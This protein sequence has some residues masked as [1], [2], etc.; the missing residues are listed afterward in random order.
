MSY[1]YLMS[2]RRHIQ[3][4]VTV[5]KCYERQSHT[6]G[7]P[8]ILNGRYQAVLVSILDSLLYAYLVRAKTLHRTRTFL[9]VQHVLYVNS[10]V[11]K[12][13]A[14]SE[15]CLCYRI[16]ISTYF[17]E[18]PLTSSCVVN[19][20]KHVNVVSSRSRKYGRW[21]QRVD[22]KNIEEPATTSCRQTGKADVFYLKT[23][24][25][26]NGMKRICL[27]NELDHLLIQTTFQLN[28]K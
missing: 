28:Y 14:I 16:R 22:Q 9:S 17:Y 25:L 3:V 12:F 23:K 26:A 5:L 15:L 4:Q 19:Q 2:K 18:V 8:Q 1:R 7:K 24:Y 11:H 13:I 27:N 6:T 20:R 10:L 21:K